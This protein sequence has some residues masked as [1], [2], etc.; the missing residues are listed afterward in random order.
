MKEAPLISSTK[1]LALCTEWTIVVGRHRFDFL[2]PF[3]S[4]PHPVLIVLPHFSHGQPGS[5]AISTY[6]CFQVGE[7]RFCASMEP[8]YLT[9]ALNMLFLT[10]SF[11]IFF[12]RC[13]LISLLS[14]GETE[15]QTLMS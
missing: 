4:S 8:F 11:R 3:L 12:G 2:S 9:Q 14:L 5:H 13:T 10:S 6:L 1:S 15:A 7:D